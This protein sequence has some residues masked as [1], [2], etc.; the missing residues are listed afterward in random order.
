MGKITYF[1]KKQIG[2]E[3][4]SFSVEGENLHDVIMAKRKLSFPNIT[5]CGICGCTKL[6]L[7]AHVT[8]ED[9]YTYTYI[10]CLNPQCKATLNF[11]QQKKDTD[12]FYL[13]TKDDGQG[14]KI[15]DWKP[16]DGA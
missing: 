15:F 9:K 16:Y 6:D 11:G 4:H 10:R 1:T 2:E 12:V 3:L 13:R 7:G 5:Q 8:D 14:N